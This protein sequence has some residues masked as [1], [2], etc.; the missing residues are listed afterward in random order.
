M[1][2]SLSTV[3][4]QSVLG[5]LFLPNILL[6]SSHTAEAASEPPD[7]VCRSITSNDE[8]IATADVVLVGSGPGGAGFLHRFVR[9]RPDLSVI[10]IEK[11]RDFKALNWPEDI[12]KVNK[13]VLTA[14][15]RKAMTWITGYGW[16]NFGGGDAGNSGEPII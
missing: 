13:E 15:P 14:F 3:L 12:A 11:G 7:E 5:V 16:N 8:P 6:S 9:Q 2:L 1:R 4:I 10:W